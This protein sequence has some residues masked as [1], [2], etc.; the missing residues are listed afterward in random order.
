MRN[1]IQQNPTEYDLTPMTRA[2][3]IAWCLF[4]LVLMLALPIIGL[5]IVLSP[6]AHGLTRQHPPLCDNC[7][8]LSGPNVLPVYR[9][10]YVL[11]T[12]DGEPERTKIP[13]GTTHRCYYCSQVQQLPPSESV[14]AW[15]AARCWERGWGYVPLEVGP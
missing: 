13:A 12:D 11:F 10:S 8:N 4:W 7:R 2:E 9:E 6:E 15:N 3:E 1:R 5:I 14:R